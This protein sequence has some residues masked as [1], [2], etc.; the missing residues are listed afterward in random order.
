MIFLVA[1]QYQINKTLFVSYFISLVIMKL[2][3][4]KIDIIK[5]VS[6]TMYH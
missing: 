4:N 5:T 1:L 6:Y 2:K 3:A